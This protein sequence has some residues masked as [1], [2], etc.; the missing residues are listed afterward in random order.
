MHDILFYLAF[1]AIP[2][3]V[4]KTMDFFK[5]YAKEIGGKAIVGDSLMMISAFFL[6]ALLARYAKRTKDKLMVLAASVYLVPYLLH[7]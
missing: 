3:G 6:H 7:G 5:D 2:R 4:S 1:S